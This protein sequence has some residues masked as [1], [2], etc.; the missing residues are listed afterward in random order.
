[1]SL[2]IA[3]V[4]HGRD[5][6]PWII[7]EGMHSSDSLS[8]VFAKSVH[9]SSTVLPKRFIKNDCWYDFNLALEHNS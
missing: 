3:W 8:S 7:L 2:L 4:I 1:M 5:D 6:L 9:I